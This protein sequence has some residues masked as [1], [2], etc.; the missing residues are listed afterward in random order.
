MAVVLVTHDWGVV[1]DL[2]DRALVLRHGRVLEAASVLDLFQRPAHPYTRALLLA[3]PHGAAPGQ[4]LPT[5]EET[6]AR[7]S[8]PATQHG[9]AAEPAR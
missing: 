3:N 8:A 5:V 6:M 2:C 9:T 1:A 4:A 7:A